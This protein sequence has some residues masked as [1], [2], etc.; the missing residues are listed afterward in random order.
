MKKE[1]KWIRT[2][3]ITAFIII[4]V[5]ISFVISFYPYPNSLELKIAYGVIVIAVIY[6]IWAVYVLTK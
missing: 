5:F 4:F 3:L 6:G 2:G 1:N